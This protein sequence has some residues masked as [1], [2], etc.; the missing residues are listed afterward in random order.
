MLKAG[1][2]SI[3]T[4]LQSPLTMSSLEIAELTGKRHGHVMRDIRN[5]LENLEEGTQSSFGSSY[6][7]TTGRSLPS[8]HLPKR[9]CLILVSGY[10][11]KMRARIIDRWMELEQ[12]PAKP[13]KVRA[14]RRTLPA[15]PE[16]TGQTLTEIDLYALLMNAQMRVERGEA[17]NTA[18]ALYSVLE[19]RINRDAGTRTS[20]KILLRLPKDSTSA[21]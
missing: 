12:A 20:G 9:E 18:D 3:T 14:H 8:Y 1:Q 4:S 21:H 19:D 13:V 11:V 16:P 2:P 17:S 6:R 15:R 10:D 5:I 7:D